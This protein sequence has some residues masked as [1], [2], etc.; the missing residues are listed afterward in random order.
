MPL[1]IVFIGFLFWD[2]FRAGFGSLLTSSP[3]IPVGF[4]LDWVYSSQMSF[5]HIPTQI[6]TILGAPLVIIFHRVLVFGPDSGWIGIFI[7]QWSLIPAGFGLAC[8]YF[9]NAVLGIFIVLSRQAPP[10]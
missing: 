5:N 1:V 3:L 8:T 9:S 4:G 7:S 6:I 10:Y 2:N